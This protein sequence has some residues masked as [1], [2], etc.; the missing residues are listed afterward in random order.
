MK[1]ANIKQFFIGHLL[2]LLLGGFIYI[3]FRATSLK[4]F[5]WFGFLGLSEYILLLRK[6]VSLKA[7]GFL[8][9]ALPDGLWLFSY[10][11]LVLL[12][13]DNR[14]DRANLCWLGIVP[15]LAIAS[16][17]GQ[18]LN[19]VP[20]TFDTADLIMYGCATALPF[21]IY[22]KSITFKTIQT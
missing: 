7:N 1:P 8:F 16:E 22:R 17:F 15:A 9:F 14:V 13:W 20:G 5:S 21:I 4:M 10:M 11:S 19:L 12:I 18:Y 6:A 3:L 2:T